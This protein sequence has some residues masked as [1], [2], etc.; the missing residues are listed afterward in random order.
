MIDIMNLA[1]KININAAP[2]STTHHINYYHNQYHD[3]SM[4]FYNS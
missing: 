1:S 4:F 3:E 2:F